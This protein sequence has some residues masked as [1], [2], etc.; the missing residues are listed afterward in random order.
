MGEPTSDFG[1][2]GWATSHD[3]G[4]ELKLGVSP[5]PP[6]AREALPDRYGIPLFELLIVD[7]SYLFVSWEIT[8][9][10]LAQAQS[11]MGEEAFAQRR[12]LLRIADEAQPTEP[13]LVSELFGEQGRWFIQHGLAGRRIIA[14]LGYDA[15][16][17]FHRLQ[18]TGP[19][20]L[21]R[22]FVIEPTGYD[23][24]RVRYGRG[25]TGEL[26]LLGIESHEDRGW[27]AVSLPGPRAADLADQHQP[28]AV[29]GSRTWQKEDRDD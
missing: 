26:T 20:S 22:D 5:A 17:A 8:P 29:P 25:E 10:Q 18:S 12:L 19:L 16:G 1:Q 6:P 23:E 11:T 15:A 2:R 21:P 7:T 14:E 13:L 27:P 3:G 24:L 9:E 4:R 28:Y